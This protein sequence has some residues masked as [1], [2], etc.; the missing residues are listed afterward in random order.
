MWCGVFMYSTMFF[1]QLHPLAR[2]LRKAAPKRGHVADEQDPA[3]IRTQTRIAVSALD[4]D[5]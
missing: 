1:L 3:L 5:N 2:S 4:Y